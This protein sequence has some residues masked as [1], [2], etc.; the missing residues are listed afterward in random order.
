MRDGAKAKLIKHTV[1]LRTHT[2]FEKPEFLGK[3]TETEKGV[4]NSFKKKNL[5]VLF[6]RRLAKGLR[7]GS[8]QGQGQES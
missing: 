2:N 8:A 1:T 7:E 5:I 3:T 6:H 4:L